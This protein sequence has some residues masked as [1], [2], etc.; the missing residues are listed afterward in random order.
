MGMAS[1]QWQTDAPIGSIVLRETPGI[2]WRTVATV[3]HGVLMQL[4]KDGGVG[5][6]AHGNEGARIVQIARRPTDETVAFVSFGKYPYRVDQGCIGTAT[7]DGAKGGV[8]REHV[9]C[10]RG[11]R[12]IAYSSP[13][14][15]DMEKSQRVVAIKN[16]GMASGIWVE[17]A[18]DD[19]LSHIKLVSHY[20]DPLT[21][22]II[23]LQYSTKRLAVFEVVF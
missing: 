18:I 12:G 17:A 3:G 5:D 21:I 6:A 11:D 10:H 4:F 7:C 16:K 22:A 20:F 2:P 23:F 19:W 8:G 9:D 13:A 15:V 1:C 14:P